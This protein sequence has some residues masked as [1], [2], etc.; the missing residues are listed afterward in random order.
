[1]SRSIHLICNAHLDPVW[2]WEWEEGAAAAISTFRT[3]A[4][5]CEEYGAFIF[6]H[7]EVILY[8]WVEAYEPA[9]FARIQRL[10]K[11]GRW[12]IMSGWY[13]QPDCNM[14]SGES[15]VRQILLGRSYFAEK[16]GARPTTAINFDPFGH[17]RGPVQIMARSGFDSYIF[18]RPGEEDIHLPQGAFT[19]EG[20]D[21]SRVMA[22]RPFGH[23]LSPLGRVNEKVESYRKTCPEETPGI[24]L[25]GVGNHGGGPS[26][27]DIQIL[28]RLIAENNQER[29]CH[30]TPE[31]YFAEVRDLGQKLPVHKGDIN[32]WAVGCYTS[33]ALS[34]YK[35]R[36]LENELYATEKMVTAAWA[37]NRITY[38]GEALQEAM[39][40]LATAEF[41]DILP[42]SSIQPVE[43]MAL[44]L[45]NHGLELLSRAKAQAFFALAEG[46]PAAREN[47]IPILVYNPHPYPVEAVVECEFQLADQNWAGDFTNAVAYQ[48]GQDLPTQVE[49]EASSLNLDWRKKVAFRAKLA[50][51]QMN[52]FD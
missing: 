32:A 11:E 23:Y 37:Q 2:L 12:H 45:M 19:W 49:Q 4:D 7:N 48:G 36:L 28:D 44:R 30:S 17:T 39:R 15:F 38:P 42:G 22:V 50:P 14:P 52:R 51:G 10:V 46:Q 6:N 27:A 35:H 8:Q 47:E 18:C 24:L 41:H 20:Y 43:E 34:K 1:M 5:L 13:L 21:G 9:L 16:F 26:R 31:A 29:L 25:W 40:T 33:M 3:A